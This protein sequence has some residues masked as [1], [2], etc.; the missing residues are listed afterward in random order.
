MSIRPQPFASTDQ[1]DVLGLRPEPG[2]SI[3]DHVGNMNPGDDEVNL[4]LLVKRTA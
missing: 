3:G 4:V 2:I 1:K